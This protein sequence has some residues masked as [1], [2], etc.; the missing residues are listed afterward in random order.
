MKDKTIKNAIKRVG[1]RRIQCHKVDAPGPVYAIR[2]AVSSFA[3]RLSRIAKLY[4]GKHKIKPDHIKLAAK[5]LGFNVYGVTKNSKVKSVK[6]I[7]K[8]D[9]V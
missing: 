7:I 8:V 2:S 5:S 6:K 1:I 9:N 3:F 4:A